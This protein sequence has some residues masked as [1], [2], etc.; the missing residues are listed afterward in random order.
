MSSTILST[1]RTSAIA[2]KTKIKSLEPQQARSRES[3]Q[4]LLRAATE[5]LGQH[6]VEGATI[7]R[8][9]QHAGLTPGS[10]YRRFHDKEALLESAILGLLER[11]DAVS[12]TFT[13]EMA[14]EIPLRVLSDQIIN[15]LVVGYRARAPLIRA[16][17]QLVDGRPSSAFKKKASRLEM[18]S[19]ERIVDLFMTHSDR[20]QHPNPRIAVS[21]ALMIVVSTVHELVVRH[22]DLGRWKHLLPEDDQ[23]LKR[24]LVRASLSYLGVDDAAGAAGKMEAEQ[25]AAMKRWR[26]RTSHYV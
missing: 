21:T 6:G 25:M 26:E 3:L 5:V 9:A 13:L 15:N 20:I 12:R 8:I 19:F 2:K 16:I 23:A 24:E 4:K 22:T 17:H 7:P 11:Q 1:R 18:Q 14:R 10:V